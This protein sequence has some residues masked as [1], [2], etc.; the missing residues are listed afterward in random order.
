MD[1]PAP[2]PTPAS[3]VR[4]LGFG[5]ER[6]GLAVLAVPRLSVA[7]VVVVLLACAT[8]VPRVGFEGS[9]VSVLD[10][11]A[12]SFRAFVEQATGFH[13][14]SGDVSVI[15]RSPDLVTAGTMERLRG[16][17]L[18]L[19]L[20][21]DVESVFSVFTI[22]DAVP[23]DGT[24][25]LLPEVFET[26]AQTR[27]AVA[28]L[29]ER[30]P[31]LR[32][33]LAPDAGALLLLM[34]LTT[35]VQMSETGLAN[36]LG[37]LR[38]TVEANV[39]EGVAVS[40]SGMPQIRSSVVDAII[41]DQT[42][43]S[44]MGILLGAAVAWLIFGRLGAALVCTIPAFVALVMVLAAFGL[45]GVRLNFFTT[46]LPTLVLVITFADTI[47]LYYKW[48]GLLGEGTMT[49][50]E[51]LRAAIVRVGPASSLT[52]ITTAIAF[53]SF[54]WAE[55]EA[56]DQLALYG[57]LSVLFAFLAMIVTLPLA[58]H[59]LAGPLRLSG[60]S[61]G[62]RLSGKGAAIA[63]MTTAAP[64]T[65]VALALAALLVFAW[66]YT[67][68]RPSYAISDYL[69]AGSEIE[70]AE[71]FA[72]D[73]FGGTSQFYV[74][75]PVTPGGSFADADNRARLIAVHDAV[76]AVFGPART[77]SLAVAWRRARSDDQIAQVAE[78]L[79]EAP[80]ALRGRFLS[81]TGDRVQVA[82]T[83]STSGSTLVV[84]ER[85]AELRKRLDALPFGNDVTITGLNVLLADTF[86]KVVEELRVGLLVSILVGVAVVA[87]A[88]RSARLALAALLPNLLPILGAQAFIW[89]MGAPLSVTNVIALT[90]AFGIAI[91]NAVHVIN[92]YDRVR[93][94]T[95]TVGGDV[96]LAVGDIAPALFASTAIIC[97]AAGITQAS[98]LPSVVELGFLLI[99][100]LVVAL[101][102]N[103][104][105]LP[106]AMILALSIGRAEGH[107][108]PQGA[109][110]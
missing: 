70:N 8:Q 31:A 9:V 53:A 71:R 30:E 5:L 16:L 93:G 49:P 68:L 73:T 17:H 27:S 20:E 40:F 26:D 87:V 69:P 99:A 22:G 60:R 46:A 63:K 103:L 47:V 110:P 75:V 52:S 15:L 94:R 101:V 45:T 84:E 43:L 78:A 56:M 36:R 88:T 105:V 74:V 106:S 41:Q 54:A 12:P 18:D 51:A 67:Q 107:A 109:K 57:V 97:V 98:A 91:D 55:T 28:A 24:E 39:P 3:P 25:P 86:P 6:I 81:T 64:A 1:E 65:T 76:E 48:Q 61:G 32:S 13:D 62:A 83:A 7:L 96:R 79:E 85:V 14:F 92:A 66:T 34:R 35:D 44:S 37:E 33:I 19:S 58:I 4:S 11:D 77:Q 72:D 82:A 23:P 21:E 108:A 2:V 42:R 89:A 59:Y 95:G 100:T 80:P 104:A 29:M 90:I 38:A 102:A 10:E 50:G